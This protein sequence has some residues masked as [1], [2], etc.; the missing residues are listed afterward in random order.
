[1]RRIQDGLAASC[2]A[3]VRSARSRE[4]LSLL[5][6]ILAITIL[7][8]AMVMIAQLV[9]LGVRSAENASQISEAQ[10]HC[11]AKMAELSAG[12]LALESTSNTEIEESPGWS[13]SV[14]VQNAD[15]VGLL[16]VRVSVERNDVVGATNR[17]YQLTRLMPDPDYDP[18]EP[19]EE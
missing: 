4:G 9:R 2:V 13:Y 12:L 18:Y 11:D 15:L 17:S 14:D 19:V 10:I 8:V 6:V 7:G 1:M 16:K 3:R 5:E